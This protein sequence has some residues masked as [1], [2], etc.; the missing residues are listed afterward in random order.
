MTV[1]GCGSCVGMVNVVS[2]FCPRITKKLLKSIYDLTRKGR[3]FAWGEKETAF[4]EVESRLQKPLVL[5]LPDN[6]GGFL[7]Y[8][9][10]SKFATIS[11]LYQIQ[12]SKPN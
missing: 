9:D 2:I 6:K 7:L 4:D 12:N 3:P 11:A 10:T 8:L 1:N 5:H